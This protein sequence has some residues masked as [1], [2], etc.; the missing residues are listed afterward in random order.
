[1]HYVRAGDPDAH[2]KGWIIVH[3]FEISKSSDTC[4]HLMRLEQTHMCSPTMSLNS[5]RS[6]ASSRSFA[7]TSTCT[8]SHYSSPLRLSI[9]FHQSSVRLVHGAN[10]PV[11]EL[12]ML[13]GQE[14]EDD[15]NHWIVI[16]EKDVWF[17]EWH[18]SYT[19]WWWGH[20]TGPDLN[21]T[22]LF[23]WLRR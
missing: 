10:D 9:L 5:S 1:M 17:H 22:G 14:Y 21:T 3:T 6:Y 11:D 19:V 18:V 23:S 4:N 13:C 15:W 2:N 12:W 20:Y 7:E 8:G 16:I